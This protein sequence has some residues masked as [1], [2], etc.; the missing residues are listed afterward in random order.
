MQRD[1][2]QP[3]LNWADL[4]LGLAQYADGHRSE[5]NDVFQR[6]ASRGPFSKSDAD[7]PLA[8]FFVDT[9]QQMTSEHPIDPKAMKPGGSGGVGPAAWLLYG[10]KDWE[11]GDI[12][13]GAALFRLF[14]Q[15]EFTGPDAWLE[16][17]KPMATDYLEQYL[18]YQMAADRWKAAQTIDQKRA[19]VAA[20]K[21]VHG[22]LGPKAQELAVT[23]A[24]DL[25]KAEKARAD[26]LA[27][28]KVPNGRY[29]LLNRKTGKTIEVEGHSKDDGHKLQQADFKNAGNQQWTI[30]GQPNGYALLIAVESGKALNV[31]GGKSEDGVAL[32]QA[33]VNKGP[34]QLWKIEKAEGNFFKLTSESSG[35]TL[36]VGGD[37]AGAPII[38]TTYTGAPEQQWKIEPL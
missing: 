10:V 24:A 1:R 38:Q 14:R 22:K 32:Q 2:P 4:L 37:A 30:T 18:S 34:T 29:R 25:A 35:K 27:S 3:W 17:L 19:A 21:D 6:L 23:A 9:A 11:I 12:E 31:P 16:G 33:N 7:L 5:A 13:E 28:G 36:A 15:S 20:L 8:N 26:L